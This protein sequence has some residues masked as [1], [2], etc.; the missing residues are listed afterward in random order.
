M[1]MGYNL[2]KY[3]PCFII[4]NQ[5]KIAWNDKSTVCPTMSIDIKAPT[6][7]YN[8]PRY[9]DNVEQTLEKAAITV[10]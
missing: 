2:S 3:V 5:P 10:F 6:M 8:A 4:S 1:T 9:A 7:G